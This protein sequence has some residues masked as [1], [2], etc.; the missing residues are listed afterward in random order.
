MPGAPEP[1]DHAP[2]RAITSGSATWT[3][4]QDTRTPGAGGWPADLLAVALL[5]ARPNPIETFY[6]L[7]SLLE[8][9]NTQLMDPRLT[10][11]LASASVDSVEAIAALYGIL[12]VRR[13]RQVSLTKLSKALHRKR[14]ALLPLYDQNIR[15]CYLEI[16]EA[17]VPHA[18][19]RSWTDFVRVWATAVQHDL[20]SQHDLWLELAALAPGPE[21]TPLRALDIVGWH[22]GR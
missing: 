17:P 6:G 5:N 3:L 4:T 15:R 16:G 18:V 2:E 11:S 20:R 7:E 19:E 1:G 12:D 13:P 22:L 21:I 9:I 8:P 10:G 14:P